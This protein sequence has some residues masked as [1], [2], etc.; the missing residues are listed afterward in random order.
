MAFIGARNLY[1][2]FVRE[3]VKI[4]AIDEVTSPTT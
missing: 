4:R 2:E 3:V 1:Y